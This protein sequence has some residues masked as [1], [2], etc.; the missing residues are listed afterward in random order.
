MIHTDSQPSTDVAF[1]NARS[2]YRFPIHPQ[3]GEIGAY[4]NAGKFCFQHST[5]RILKTLNLI[6]GASKRASQL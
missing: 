2:K 4:R 5:Q 6:Q 1:G 3:D